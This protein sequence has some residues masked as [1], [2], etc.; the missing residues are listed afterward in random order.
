[1]C[2]DL[3]IRSA[4]GFLPRADFSLNP[5]LGL[6]GD[7]AWRSSFGGNGLAYGKINHARIFKKR[8]LGPQASC[9]VCYR[10]D[11]HSGF[12]RE[13]GAAGAVFPLFSIGR[14]CAFGKNDDPT[15]FGQDFLTL[16][17]DLFQ[18]I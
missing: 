14:T 13:F 5:L 3:R 10:H 8:T 7:F 6:R 9:V 18:R 4:Q 17:Y 2:P 11:R 1:M 16:G 15:A 12:D